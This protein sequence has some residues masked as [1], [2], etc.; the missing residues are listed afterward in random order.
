MIDTWLAR[1]THQL[2]APER[3][4]SFGQIS[5]AL[6]PLATVVVAH[7]MPS[8]YLTFIRWGWMKQHPRP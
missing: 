2:D 8:V 1:G 7:L 6:R 5:I 3:V 4:F